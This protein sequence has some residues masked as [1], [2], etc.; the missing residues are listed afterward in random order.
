VATV[1]SG[2]PTVLV[3]EG[4]YALDALGTNLLAFLDGFGDA[5]R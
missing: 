2:L 3:Q 4:G 5:R 1:R